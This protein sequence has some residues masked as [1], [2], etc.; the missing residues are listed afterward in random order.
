L[1]KIFIIYLKVRGS[2]KRNFMN[3]FSKTL[4]WNN[5]IIMRKNDNFLAIIKQI[6]YK[7]IK[8][9]ESQSQIQGGFIWI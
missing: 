5:T 2:Q 3:K 7:I 9:K 4:K 6:W 8:V 1:I